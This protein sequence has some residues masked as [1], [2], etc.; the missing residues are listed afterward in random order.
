MT[1]EARAAVKAGAQ[2]VRGQRHALKFCLPGSN[3]PDG[4]SRLSRDILWKNSNL[5]TGGVIMIIA[6]QH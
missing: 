5:V 2:R 3:Q 6:N 1:P 4:G